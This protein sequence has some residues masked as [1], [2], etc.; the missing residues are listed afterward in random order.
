VAVATVEHIFD[1][2]EGLGQ[3]RR[4]PRQRLYKAL[5]PL[6]NRPEG[7]HGRVMPGEGVGVLVEHGAMPA[8]GRIM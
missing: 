8:Q 6:L 1:G 2:R 3:G 7:R 4:D 5:L